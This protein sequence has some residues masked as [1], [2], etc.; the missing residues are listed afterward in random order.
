MQL[1][2]DITNA[3][4][5]SLSKITVRPIN[6]RDANT[7][8]GSMTCQEFCGGKIDRNGEQIG[9]QNCLFVA[10]SDIEKNQWGGDAD[11]AKVFD[12]NS[13]YQKAK[14]YFEGGYS[15]VSCFCG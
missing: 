6:S 2:K 11:D 7:A 15:V 4:L 1:F 5:D 12:H 9:A 8:Y 10:L 3:K 13:C 14:T